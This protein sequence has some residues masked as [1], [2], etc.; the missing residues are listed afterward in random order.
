MVGDFYCLENSVRSSPRRG[1]SVTIIFSAM[2][3]VLYT[4]VIAW[5]S[6][7]MVTYIVIIGAA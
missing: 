1:L 5:I 2:R 7:L 6:P 3:P 4:T